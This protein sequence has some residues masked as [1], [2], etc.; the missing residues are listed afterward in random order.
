MLRD[1]GLT[2]M[3][4]DA[5]QIHPTTIPTDKPTPGVT[6]VHYF[7]KHSSFHDE[8]RKLHEHLAGLEE[9][10]TSEGHRFTPNELRKLRDELAREFEVPDPGTGDYYA[11]NPIASLAQSA[12]LK[13]VK[14]TEEGYTPEDLPRWVGD[15]VLSLIWTFL[16][17]KHEF[18]DTPATANLADDARLVLVADWGTGCEAAQRV[19]EQMKSWVDKSDRPTHV[20]HLGDTYPSGTPEEGQENVL[21]L[22]PVAVKR[23]AVV[24][25]W[26]LNGNH[27]MYSG[28][29]GLFKTILGDPRFRPQQAQAKPTSWF[30]LRSNQWD[31]LGLDTAWRDP[32]ADL[33][34]G[35]LFW[36]GA[37][38]YLEGSQARYVADR[39]AE[40]TERSDKRILLLTHHQMFSSYDPDA[41]KDDRIAKQLQSALEQ[42]AVDAWFWGHEHD[43]L[44]YQPYR[45]VTAARAIGHGGVPTLARTTPPIRPLDPDRFPDVGVPEP[46]SPPSPLSE[47]LAW[48]YRGA[49]P[50][51]SE[52]KIWA[53]RG[54]AVVDLNGLQL[55]VT[56]VDEEGDIAYKET[57]G[58]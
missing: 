39:L 5:A 22:W 36:F 7:L 46:G 15:I 29:N 2:N 40:R 8:L 50:I 56:Y 53:K 32:L 55:D 19:G 30:H 9:A 16:H 4:G 1:V 20:I 58:A 17:G 28:G 25:S 13:H 43:C 3:A 47:Q 57:I 6:E 33:E 48:E 27:D 12:M 45:N 42:H 26:A 14:A 31:V 51:D 10:I 38:G 24:G 41:T 34:G 21:D 11:R 44:A 23:A 49:L 54:F 18:N 52:G 37:L 35:K